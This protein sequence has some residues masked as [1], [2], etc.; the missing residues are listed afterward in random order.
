VRRS[1][2]TKV[3]LLRRLVKNPVLIFYDKERTEALLSC[4][5]RQ[6]WPSILT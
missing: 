3:A 4:D 1:P 5:Q 2:P 6:R